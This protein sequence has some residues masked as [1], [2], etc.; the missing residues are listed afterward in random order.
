MSQQ[1]NHTEFRISILEQVD[2]ILKNC[3]E[4]KRP[5][6]MDPARSELFDLFATVEAAGGLVEDSPI[7]LS[8]D[9]LC[10]ALAQKWGLKAATETSV[11][12]NSQLN[13]EQLSQMRILWSLL[14]LWMEW[15]YAW[16]RWSDFH[17]NDG[18]RITKTTK[19]E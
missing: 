2:A 10:Q 18:S 13:T 9:G 17:N 3:E 15:T 12:E 19:S 1:Q 8:A 4:A 5:I 11:R 7:D 14:R 16:N 6:E